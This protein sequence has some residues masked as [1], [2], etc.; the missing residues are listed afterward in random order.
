MFAR[1]QPRRP[2]HVKRRLNC[3]FMTENCLPQRG[4]PWRRNRLAAA[5]H[6]KQQPP[7][8]SQTPQPPHPALY[9][10]HH[11]RDSHH[12]RRGSRHTRLSQVVSCVRP[13]CV[14]LVEDIERR[15]ADVGDFILLRG[16]FVL[17]WVCV[18]IA[19]TGPTPWADA[20]LANDN[21]PA[22][23]KALLLRFRVESCF[24]CDMTETSFGRSYKSMTPC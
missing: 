23:P 5:P 24:A 9:H 15:Q 6:D 12:H 18:G 8:P 10:C 17:V 2:C 4:T 1:R 3:A 16:I 20:P 11:R 14:F 19:P 21:N 22:A 7:P 13:M